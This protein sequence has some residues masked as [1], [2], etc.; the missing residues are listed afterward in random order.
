MQT[1]VAEEGNELDSELQDETTEQGGEG[2]E[3]EDGGEEGSEGSEGAEGTEQGG[4]GE[5]EHVIGFGSEEPP[6]S[7]TRGSGDSEVFSDLRKRY[8]ELRQENERLQR[9]LG[10]GQPTNQQQ[11]PKLRVKPTLAGN[12]YDEE[13]YQTDLEKW[14]AEKRDIESWEAG[15]AQAVKAN[16]ERAR[17]VNEAYQASRAALKVKNFDE[18]EEVV[19]TALPEEWQQG[20]IK[21]GAA[22][23]A[24]LVVALG[25]NPK[26]LQELAS[27]KDPVKFTWAAAQLE[28]DM[29]V[30]KRSTTKPAP[31]STVRSGSGGSSASSSSSASK[32]TLERLQ[33]EADR[34]GDRTKVAAFLRKQRQAGLK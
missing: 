2:D 33:A 9:Q 10:S 8:R 18:A 27:I 11:P 30:T 16:E 31:E 4:D 21:V 1:G 24:A 12:E 34:T 22:N 23:P 3:P 26:K 29:K 25:T 14:Y 15:Q 6:T 7:E 19:M 13:K 5:D 17:K 32:A 20:V 28:K